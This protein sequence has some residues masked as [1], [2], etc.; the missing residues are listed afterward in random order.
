MTAV[1]L[2][3]KRYQ[4]PVMPTSIKNQPA[5]FQRVM[6][7]VLQGLDCAGIYINDI[8]IG[9]SGDTE[10]KLLA[11]HDRHVRAVLDRLQ[12]E[13]LVPSVGKTDFPVRSVELCGHVLEDGTRRL[14][15]GRTLGQT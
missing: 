5:I 3:G 8:I 2:A 4:W 1:N 9:S 6:D 13:E 12:K 7:H 11:N 10:D 14:V 15:P